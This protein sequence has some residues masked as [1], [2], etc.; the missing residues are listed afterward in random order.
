MRKLLGKIEQL[1]KIRGT[2]QNY[3]S[4]KRAKM[5]LYNYVQVKMKNI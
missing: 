4:K 3:Q 5:F 2:R 1:S